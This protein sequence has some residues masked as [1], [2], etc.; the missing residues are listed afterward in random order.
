MEKS[1][2][3]QAINLGLYLGIALC[4][5]T[6]IGY[7]VDLG[8]LVN[9]WVI[10]L[11]LPVAIIIFGIFATAKIKQNLGG[12]L[13][14]KEAF[15]SYFITVSIGLIISSTFSVILFNFI[16]TYAAIEVKNILISN[17]EN[18]MKNMGAPL[19]KIADSIEKIEE[20]NTFAIGTQFKSLMQSIIFF[21][22][23]GLIVAAAMKKSKPDTE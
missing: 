13:S 20:Q 6:V 1:L 10:L 8:I 22:V 19:E 12:F 4:L 14:F 7:A 16:D 23:I 18:M 11:I 21:A 5:F 3:S 15:S 9:Y 17:T 2:K